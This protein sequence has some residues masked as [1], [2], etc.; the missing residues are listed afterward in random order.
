MNYNTFVLFNY[1]LNKLSMDTLQNG[2]KQVLRF[3]AKVW[4]RQP[5]NIH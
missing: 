5:S 1:W 3:D 4:E 2:V